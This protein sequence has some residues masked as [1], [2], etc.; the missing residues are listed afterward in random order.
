MSVA[1]IDGPGAESTGTPR[2]PLSHL[3]RHSLRLGQTHPTLHLVRQHRGDTSPLLAVPAGAAAQPP[4]APVLA[5]TLHQRVTE[6]PPLP[7]AVM[8]ALSAVGQERVS[9][10]ECTQHIEHDLALATQTLTLANSPF[11]GVSGRVATISDAIHILGLRTLAQLLATAAVT[12]RFAGLRS[13][14]IDTKG[15][16]RHAIAT[17]IAAQAIALLRDFDPAQAF[18]A[19]LLHDVGRLALATQHGDEL[20]AT[21]DWAHGAD[22]PMLDAERA[23]LGLDHTE[24][25]VTIAS[26]WRFPQ[27]VI[28]AIGG[29]HAPPAGG[30]VTLADVV[31][32]ADA[33]V[34]GL[35]LT[36]DV[37]E[38]VPGMDLNSWARLG[39]TAEQGL[40]VLSTAE[41]GA[42]SLGQSLGC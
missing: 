20:V 16:W 41:A 11:F 34:H 30:P 9:I 7:Q 37:H 5:A 40:S 33:L 32:A 27:G 8:Q 4:R 42:N 21:V 39:L 10:D 3:F 1:R 6:L 17:G 36:G 24:A 15:F 18:L 22:A 29:H 19:G 14:G 13:S 28:D 26:Y 25:G 31:H 38:A 2:S 35:N 23:V 12:S